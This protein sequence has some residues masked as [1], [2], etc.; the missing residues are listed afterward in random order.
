MVHNKYLR[1]YGSGMESVVIYLTDNDI[2]SDVRYK[3]QKM[4]FTKMWSFLIW[5]QRKLLVIEEVSMKYKF[6]LL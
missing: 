1:L 6:I 2:L 3:Y 5:Q 4:V